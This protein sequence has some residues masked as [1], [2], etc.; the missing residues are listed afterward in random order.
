MYF[1]EQSL[2][3]LPFFYYCFYLIF[4]DVAIITIDIDYV[5]AMLPA[6][7]LLLI[8]VAEV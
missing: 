7:N 5:V 1:P 3:F 4:R 6:V 2:A 8:R